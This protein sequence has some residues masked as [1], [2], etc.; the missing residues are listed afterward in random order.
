MVKKQTRLAELLSGMLLEGVIFPEAEDVVG[1]AEEMEKEEVTFEGMSAE[2]NKCMFD[3]RIAMIKLKEAGRMGG[4][5]GR[6][7]E[8][9]KE[10]I[11]NIVEEKRK[12]EEEKRNMVEETKKLE[13]ENRRVIEEKKETEERMKRVEEA[14]IKL[15]EEVRNLSRMNGRME[16]VR[17][18]AEEEKKKL[19][20]EV[21]N[22][23]R[24]N[25]RADRVIFPPISSLSS[26]PLTFSDPARIKI[27]NNTI[28]HLGYQDWDSCLLDIF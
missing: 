14:K 7:R 28:I 9:G 8:M 20:E 22:L 4:I 27:E 5:K 16:E 11:E 13:E 19:E 25:G 2:M 21:G 26:L 12:L 23:Q 18:R 3:F 24:M 10:E 6:K 15:E 1:V 17:R